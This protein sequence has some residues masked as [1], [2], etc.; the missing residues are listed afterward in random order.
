MRLIFGSLLFNQLTTQSL[1]G[2]ISHQ[3][4]HT[5]TT[6]SDP[7]AISLNQWA[8]II[9]RGKEK[10]IVIRMAMTKALRLR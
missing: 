1:A 8:P 3:L 2:V 5:I 4:P 7:T 9:I 10:I 6:D